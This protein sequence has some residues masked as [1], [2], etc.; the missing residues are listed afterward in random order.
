MYDYTW[1]R[2]SNDIERRV[3]VPSVLCGGCSVDG[4]SRARRYARRGPVHASGRPL[5]RSISL[6]CCM[7]HCAFERRKC[8]L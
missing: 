5:G 1:L 6:L 4:C 3:R 2:C 7:H 8:K